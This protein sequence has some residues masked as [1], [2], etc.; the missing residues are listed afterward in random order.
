M[1]LITGKLVHGFSAPG[2]IHI[3]TLY[4]KKLTL[5]SN[6]LCSK[7]CNFEH[8]E[9]MNNWRDTEPFFHGLSVFLNSCLSFA[10]G[11]SFLN[12]LLCHWYV[13]PKDYKISI[14]SLFS[15]LFRS[16]IFLVQFAVYN[17]ACRLTIKQWKRIA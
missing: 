2:N 9:P 6:A 17:T 12:G 1:F 7:L 13:H 14:W 5:R 16:L 4:H 11:F 10:A 8:R 3:S 15:V